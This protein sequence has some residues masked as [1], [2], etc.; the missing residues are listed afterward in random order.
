ML[1]ATSFKAADP[2]EVTSVGFTLV[3]ANIF[4]SSGTPVTSSGTL[5]GS[6]LPQPNNLVF[7][8]PA[9]T[10]TVTPSFR[11]L[12]NADVTGVSTLLALTTV[13]TLAS[14]VMTTPALG[15][16]ASGVLT[17]CTNRITLGTSVASTSGTLVAFTGLS[18]AKQI[19]VSFSGVSTN[20]TSK[21]QIQLGTGAGPTYTTSGYLGAIGQ[22]SD[23]GGGVAAI[24]TTNLSAGF[25]TDNAASASAVRHGAVVLTLENTSTNVW[26][27]TG[28]VNRSDST[29]VSNLGGSVPLAA[30]L[31]AVGIAAVNGTDAFDAGEINIAIET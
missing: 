18:S 27:A 12:V 4:A 21:L 20:G 23:A 24:S 5:R 29:T 15:T 1:R 26:S 28:V 31:T 25:L 8:G 6:L 30:A 16:P 3:P 11:A 19:T 10:G 22:I 17:N 14:P 2:G 9:T 7:S 13:G